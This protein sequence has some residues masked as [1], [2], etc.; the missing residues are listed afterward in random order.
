MKVYVAGRM[1]GIHLY[2]QPW[3]EATAA[4]WR[5]AGHNVITPFDTNSRVWMRHFG[6]AFNPATDKC[7]YGDPLL[8]EM[9]A[10]DVAEAIKSDAVVLESLWQDSRGA[11]AEVVV[12]SLMSQRF[13]TEYGARMH[14][15]PRLLF[16]VAIVPAETIPL[17]EAA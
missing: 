8:T 11:R 2:N 17:P 5:A 14:I 12:A 1:S 13:Y 4:R 16:D 10:E 7:D 15:T 3:F 6:R 9:L